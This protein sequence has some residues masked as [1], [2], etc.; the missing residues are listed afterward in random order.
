[1][2][3]DN[4]LSCVETQRTCQNYILI[5]HQPKPYRW[6][7]SAEH[8]LKQAHLYLEVTFFPIGAQNL[9]TFCSMLANHPGWKQV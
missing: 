4:M 2:P 6:R 5:Y 3:I 8:F 9:H 7:F 1:M